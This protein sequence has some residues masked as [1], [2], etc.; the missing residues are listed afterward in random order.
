LY[1]LKNRRQNIIIYV[2]SYNSLEKSNLF[3][4]HFANLYFCDYNHAHVV[5][6]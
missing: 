4:S 5:D 2:I 1:R 6:F 3:S